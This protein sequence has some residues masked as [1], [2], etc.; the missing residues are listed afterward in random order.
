MHLF[1][2]LTLF[3]NNYFMLEYLP[4]Q[5]Q[6]FLLHKDFYFGIQNL[7]P[8]FHPKTLILYQFF[9]S[10]HISSITFFLF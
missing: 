2:S 3:L 4:L 5:D 7:I 9:R 6:G 8:L 10:F 1:L